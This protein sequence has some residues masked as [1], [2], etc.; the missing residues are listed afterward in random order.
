MATPFDTKFKEFTRL[1]NHFEEG[2]FRGHFLSEYLIENLTPTYVPVIMT[3]MGDAPQDTSGL[4]T[5]YN[6]S[7]TFVKNNPNTPTPATGHRGPW[8]PSCPLGIYW[9]KASPEFL[10]LHD[11]ENYEILEMEISSDKSNDV[12]FK[13]NG[14]E[15][16]PYNHY[17]ILTLDRV[18]GPVIK[19]NTGLHIYIRLKKKNL[20]S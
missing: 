1:E 19:I 11:M 20:T 7:E 17:K 10:I 15:S 6:A 9:T 4:N 18:P 16:K 8:P 14:T 3:V 13:F 5:I 2:P 12:Y